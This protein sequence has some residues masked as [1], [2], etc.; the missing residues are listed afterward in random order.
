MTEKYVLIHGAWQGEWAWL[1]VA[2]KLRSEGKEVLTFDLPGSGQDLT[3]PGNVTLE[4]YAETIISRASKFSTAGDVT[5]VGHSMGGAAVT[6]AAALAP[7]L[8]SR[9]MYVCAFAPRT[10]ESVAGL[11][12]ESNQL[13]VT[14]PKADINLEDGIATLTPEYIPG[15]FFNDCRQD[16]YQHLLQ[17]FRPQPLG[18]IIT[19]LISGAESIPLARTFII[20]TQDRAVSPALQHYM[21]ERAGISD[22]R[23]LESGHEPFISVPDELV[24]QLVTI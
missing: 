7:E 5:L 21:A 6:L 14:G 24:R 9:I 16:K 8:F 1:S 13:G 11:G 17:Y 19:P 20:C 4:G 2:E 10:G 12:E 15:T 18:P 23:V 3:L 22:I